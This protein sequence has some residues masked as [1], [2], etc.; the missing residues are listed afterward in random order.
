VKLYASWGLFYDWVKYELAR[1]TFGGD[2]WRTYYR[3]LDSLDPNVILKLGNGNLPGNNLWPTAFQD[4]RIPAF[5]KEQL[6][7]DL[8]PMSSMIT[9]AGVEW[10]VS[11][12]LVLAARYT[13]NSLRDT[14]EDIGTLVDGSEVYIYANPGRGL[15][16]MSAP[17]GITPSFELPRPKRVYDAME[18]SFTRRFG[19]RWFASGSYVWSRLYGNYAGLQNSDEIFPAGT[20]RGSL[21]SQAIFTNPYRPGTSASRAYDLDEYSYDAHG[22]I[23]YGRLASD[24]PHV[25]KLYGSYTLPSKIGDTEIG[26]FFYAGSGTPVSTLVQDVQNVPLFVNGRGDMGRT[27]VLTQ[28]DLLLGHEVRIAEGKRLRFEF[29]AQNLF[30]QK[31]SRYTYAFYNRFRTRSS[32]IDLTSLDFRQGYD[33][34]ALVAASPDAKKATGALDPRF[35]KADNF[36]TGFVGRVGIKFIF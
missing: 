28:T 19:N 17:S 3:P 4:W 13:R 34:N 22:N 12:N 11:P 9:N 20:N 18:L 27:P 2:V 25:M 6:D 10:Q 15:A 30:N 23:V 21:P 26:G 33:Y 32:G 1:G 14:I 35:N 16:R 8:N 31:T 7:P 29:N 24:R 36:N 5:G